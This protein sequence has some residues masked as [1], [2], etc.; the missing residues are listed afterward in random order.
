MKVEFKTRVQKLTEV[1]AKAII[2]K[3]QDDRKATLETI[4]EFPYTLS[5]DDESCQ[6]DIKTREKYC[7]DL[8][9]VA[10]DF[11]KLT[12]K[13]DDTILKDVSTLGGLQ[14]AENPEDHLSSFIKKE[15]LSANGFSMKNKEGKTFGINSEKMASMID[16]PA[17]FDSQVKNFIDNLPNITHKVGFD[18][19]QVMA[20]KHPAPMIPENFFNEEKK[21]FALSEPVKAKIKL[22]HSDMIESQ[23][24]LQLFFVQCQILELSDFL[25]EKYGLLLMT[26][27]DP[28]VYETDIDELVRH[29]GDRQPLLNNVSSLEPIRLKRFVKKQKN[30]R[31]KL[32]AM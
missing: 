25:R 22:F 10:A 14:D 21:T 29:T 2:E 13:G 23:E 7:K 27:T 5:F 8:N 24:E 11:L 19:D 26:E 17:D 15:Y 32:A 4:K 28:N 3:L 1:S 18:F 20:G 12:G 9:Q 30:N 31:I 6:A 16:W